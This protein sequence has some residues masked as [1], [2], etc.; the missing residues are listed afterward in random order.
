MRARSVAS[1]SRPWAACML[2]RR[3]VTCEVAGIAQVMA[4]CEITNF[5]RT[6]AQLV[7]SISAAHAGS[8]RL[9]QPAEE[10]AAGE[11][12]IREHR[13]A[14]LLRQGQESALRLALADRVVDLHEVD[15]LGPR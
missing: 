2:S 4:V 7:Q 14:A 10:I 11:R 5:S 8:G 1:G 9:A 15:R 12:T 6:C 3:C 13:H